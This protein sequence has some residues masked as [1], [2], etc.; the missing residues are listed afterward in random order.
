[1]ALRRFIRPLTA[2]A[3]CRTACPNR[4][5]AA[6]HA[7]PR[8]L[9]TSASASMAAATT[10]AEDD[11]A[12]YNEWGLDEDTLA[13]RE[14]AAQFAEHEMAPHAAQWD[15]DEEFPVDTLRAAAALGFGG[16]YTRGDVGGSE[17]S[18]LQAAV[19]FEA[20]SRACASTTAYISIHNM[21]TWMVDAFGT[22]EQRARFGPKLCAME[23]LASY[24]LTEP[25]AGSD[26]ASLKT[27][28]ELS[29]DGSHYVVNGSKAF[30]SGGG[31]SDL[32]AIM[33]RTG[34]D[35]PGGISCLLVEKG[36]EGLG[37]GG[38]ERKLGWNSQ[39]TREVV[40]ADAKVPAENVLGGNAPGA[41][42]GGLGEGFKIAM[43]GLDGGRINIAACSLGAAGASLHAAAEYVK[44]RSQFGKPLAAFQNTQ[45]KLAEM[46]T[47][48]D[49]ARLMVYRAARS[50]DADAPG[51]SRHAAMAKLFAT[52][53]G[54]DVCNQ[55]LQL[56]GGYGYLK[57]YPIERH[58]RDVRVHQILEGT[59]EIMR[60]VTS[61]DMLQNGFE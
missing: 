54:F 26:A 41:E 60:V 18:R 36:T 9:S 28:A 14:M 42:G 7:A 48:L 12:A 29:A 11:A 5:A 16:I 30:I 39:P 2:S 43:K 50:L 55:A 4:A 24:C 47:Q 35:G 53:V 56:H 22:E 10:S 44:E 45:F 15:A 23:L 1:M 20:M 33:A 32:Y 61:R 6:L 31:S 25:S 17:L 51:K 52:D 3:L 58:L 46:L 57:D 8:A 38:K 34:G 27:R 13:L 49:A 40:L 59:N 37:F 21:V 19:I